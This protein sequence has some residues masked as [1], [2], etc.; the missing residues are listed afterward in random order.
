VGGALGITIG[1]VT[2][3]GW[4]AVGGAIAVTAGV[5]YG[6]HYLF[7]DE[8]EDLQTYLPLICEQNI[9]KVRSLIKTILELL[10]LAGAKP[11]AVVNNRELTRQ[12]IEDIAKRR[13]KPGRDCCD[14]VCSAMVYGDPILE[15]EPWRR[16]HD[17]GWC[18][19]P[20]ECYD[21]CVSACKEGEIGQ[22]SGCAA[23]G[24]LFA[25]HCQ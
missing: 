3:P 5:V 7:A 15:I 13:R 25:P 9:C 8:L 23:S 4:V 14:D 18:D 12:Q 19:E 20:Q 11:V 16:P 6:I 22:C 17:A 10:G 21:N 2:V 24:I 1:A